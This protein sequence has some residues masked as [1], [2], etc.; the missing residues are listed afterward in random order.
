MCKID[1]YTNTF[2]TYYLTATPKRSKN[3]EDIIYQYYFKN[4]PKIDL[5]DEEQ[6]PHTHYRSIVFT[7]EPTPSEVSACKNKYGLDRNTYT[8]YLTNK[9]NYYNCRSGSCWL[10]EGRRYGGRDTGKC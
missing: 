1:F 6:D 4:I 3:E 7:S 2:R 8:N 5:F 9:E 10:P